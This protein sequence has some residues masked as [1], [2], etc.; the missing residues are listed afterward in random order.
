M[1]LGG[2]HHAP[3]VL[4]L[5]ERPGTHCIVGWVSPQG[6]SGRVR[7]ISPSPGI[8]SQDRPV[9]SDSL[10]RLCYRGRTIMYG[11]HKLRRI[12]LKTHITSLRYSADCISY[13]KAEYCI[14][15][16]I[17]NKRTQR[18]YNVVYKVSG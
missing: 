4:P 10:Y 5:L 2:Q 18:L 15:E 6:R 1:E 16:Y 9:C 12:Q 8:R 7:K 14:N 17:Y 3:A 11:Y 13:N